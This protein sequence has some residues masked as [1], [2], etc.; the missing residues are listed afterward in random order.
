MA[1]LKDEDCDFD[2]GIEDVRC[3]LPLGANDQKEIAII[4]QRQMAMSRVKGTARFFA[5]P[6]S[7]PVQMNV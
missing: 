4:T 1:K 3:G 2:L 5:L 6:Y 7:Y